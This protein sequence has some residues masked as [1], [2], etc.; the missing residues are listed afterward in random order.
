MVNTLAEFIELKTY[1]YTITA[2]ITP[3]VTDMNAM[4]MFNCIFFYSYDFFVKIRAKLK[5]KLMFQISEVEIFVLFYLHKG[6]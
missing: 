6:P 5:K 4:Q 2:V 3:T 1:D